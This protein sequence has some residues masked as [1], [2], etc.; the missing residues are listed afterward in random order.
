ML[1]LVQSLDGIFH[2]FPV[3]WREPEELGPSVIFL[4]CLCYL[5][6]VTEARRVEK[7][8]AGERARKQALVLFLIFKLLFLL[9]LPFFL[10]FLETSVALGSA[11]CTDPQPVVSLLS[12]VC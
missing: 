7:W 4:A 2:A 12:S 9:F 5:E 1:V 8:G 3:W 10:E 6:P 11:P